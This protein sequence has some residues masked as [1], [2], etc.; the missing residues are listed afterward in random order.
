MA[1]EWQTWEPDEWRR[2]LDELRD[3]EAWQLIVSFALGAC[4]WKLARQ[5]MWPE[6]G[7]SEIEEVA[8]ETLERIVTRLRAGAAVTKMRAYTEQVAINLLF[9]L[10]RRI[11]ERRSAQ[12]AVPTG[13]DGEPLLHDPKATAAITAVE[14]ADADS[15]RAALFLAL[16]ECLQDLPDDERQ[17]FAMLDMPRA[18]LIEQLQLDKSEHVLRNLI[19]RRKKKLAGCLAK[20]GYPAGRV[21]EILRRGGQ[22]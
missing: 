17:I 1:D 11:S 4:K 8:Y 18:W 15:E 10:Q 14:E 3:P 2:R 22:A 21:M 20:K 9:A 7:E 5:G 12:R 19:Y 6:I 13:E 16:D